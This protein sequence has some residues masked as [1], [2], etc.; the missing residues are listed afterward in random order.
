MEHHAFARVD[1]ER[2]EVEDGQAHAVLLVQDEG[3]TD[4]CTLIIFRL[5]FRCRM[6]R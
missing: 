3:F 1:G 4:V 2:G 5:W 6:R